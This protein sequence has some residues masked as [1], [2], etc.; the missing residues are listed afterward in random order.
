MNSNSLHQDSVANRVSITP[1]Y[2]TS[3]CTEDTRLT[4]SCYGKLTD[5]TSDIS[6]F[7]FVSKNNPRLP[8][9]STQSSV[10]L[11]RSLSTSMRQSEGP[12]THL[13]PSKRQVIRQTTPAAGSVLRTKP[14]LEVPK[15]RLKL[16]SSSAEVNTSPTASA[17]KSSE[18]NSIRSSLKA[19]V[20]TEPS[21]PVSVTSRL[22]RPTVASNAQSKRTGIQ[23]PPSDVVSPSSTRSLLHSP[24]LTSSP[25]TSSAKSPLFRKPGLAKASAKGTEKNRRASEV[26]SSGVRRTSGTAGATPGH[27]VSPAHQ[28]NEGAF[29]CPTDC[30]IAPS[31]PVADPD[32]GARKVLEE[33]LKASGKLID[34]LILFINWFSL[35]NE[36]RGERSERKLQ[37]LLSLLSE[38]KQE[39]LEV[40]E[41]LS[42]LSAEFSA[43][44]SDHLFTLNAERDMHKTELE[45]AKQAFEIE[46]EKE[47]DRVHKQRAADIEELQRAYESQLTEERRAWAARMTDASVEYVKKLEKQKSE[48]ETEIADLERENANRIGEMTDKFNRLK[49][50][51][52]NKV[53]LL[54]EEC[55]QLRQFS[56]EAQR[57]ATQKPSVIDESIQFPQD[58][59]ELENSILQHLQ[60][61]KSSDHSSLNRSFCSAHG[62]ACSALKRTVTLPPQPSIERN[63]SAPARSRAP[64]AVGFCSPQPARANR[65]ESEKLE[66]EIKSL[67]IVL[68]LKSNE[69][70]SLRRK[71]ME[72]EQ[73]LEEYNELKYEVSQLRHKNE[74]LNA[75]L[76]LQTEEKKA[77]EE[78]YQNLFQNLDREI[79]EKKKFKM[80]LD[81][82]KFKMDHT[83]CRMQTSLYANAGRSL[84]ET[85]DADIAPLSMT[86]SVHS[87]VRM[88]K[89]PGDSVNA[90]PNS[91][92]PIRETSIEGPPVG[93]FIS[94][95]ANPSFR[96]RG[97][98]HDRSKRRTLATSRELESRR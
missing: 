6:Y 86:R 16:T 15:S 95:S 12:A 36:V 10:L 7:G 72:Q 43:K 32:Q 51:L 93:S 68:Q 4:S 97:I 71:T 52:S 45:L 30:S 94:V 69:L 22:L 23:K 18:S 60:P 96:P 26:V 89:P 11:K 85:G 1:S 28:E 58:I 76:E 9:H 44:V 91:E 46:R 47:L 37:G 49:A 2:E 90:R 5:T 88:R 39:C 14:K 65:S 53:D 19:G 59:G 21:T 70:V 54:Q 77:L 82:L 98:Q 42:K 84:S 80:D 83:E 73:Q 24:S 81:E 38:Q 40:R 62:G 27:D 66:E 78:R 56:L 74:N 35:Q 79:R 61:D 67:N 31:P 34:V 25:T 64:L 63:Q 13:Q 29:L 55:T 50:D 17:R 3:K 57:T 41:R 33:R 92:I 8:A 20:K 87:A 48:H 75:L